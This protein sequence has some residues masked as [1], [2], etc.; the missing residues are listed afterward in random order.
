MSVNEDYQEVL[1][2]LQEQAEDLPV[3]LGLPEHDELV[4]IEEALLLPI[5]PIY[6]EFLLHASD[7]VLGSLEPAVAADPGAHNYLAEL[8][9][10]AWERGLPR[11]L[12]AFCQANGGYYVLTQEDEVQFWSEAGLEEEVAEHIWFWARD[13]WASA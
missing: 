10:E 8:A 13:I 9:A 12:L 3:P 1:E 7:L 5:P 2:A 4:D 6:R 11:E